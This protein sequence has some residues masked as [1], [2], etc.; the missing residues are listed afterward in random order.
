M[1]SRHAHEKRLV[2]TVLVVCRDCKGEGVLPDGRVCGDC[3]GNRHLA[4]DRAFDGGIPVG[5][6]EWLPPVLPNYAPPIQRCIP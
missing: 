3:M 2:S 6:K 5:F 1:V 4:V